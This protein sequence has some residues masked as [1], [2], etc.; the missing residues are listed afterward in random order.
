[1]KEQ[2]TSKEYTR[3]ILLIIASAFCF[4]LMGAFVKLS[5]DLPFVQKSFFRNLVAVFIAAGVL[6]RSGQGF[7]FRRENLPYLILRSVFGTVGILCNFY[8]IGKLMLPD[9]NILNKMSPFFAVV[10]SALFLKERIRGYQIAAVLAALG[11]AVFVIKPSFANASLGPALIGLT[12]GLGAGLAYMMVRYLGQRGERGPVVVLFFSLFSCVVCMIPMLF[13]Y[14]PMTRYQLAMLLLAGLSAAGGQLTITAAYFH[15]PANRIS[16][17][18]YTAV[19]FSTIW[20]FL[21]FGEIPD[22]YSF[23]GYFIICGAAILNFLKSRRELE[24]KGTQS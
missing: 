22:G 24:R 8:A 11:G 2:M 3:G 21:F 16:V 20:S 18:D 23:I 6:W 15:A 17:Y 19:I 14:A 10:A 9:A 13:T 4:S 7:R 1:M 12:S 5:G